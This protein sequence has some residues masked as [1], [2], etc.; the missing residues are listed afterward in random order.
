MEFDEINDIDLQIKEM[1]NN[2]KHLYLTKLL[3]EIDDIQLAKAIKYLLIMGF[4]TDKNDTN[5]FILS[6][7]ELVRYCKQEHIKISEIMIDEINDN[8]ILK[9]YLN[10]KRH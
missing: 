5:C 4:D 8:Q 10:P 6:I 3:Y 2:E 7:Y 1:S 9:D